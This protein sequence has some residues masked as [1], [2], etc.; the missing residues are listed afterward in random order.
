LRDALLAE[1]ELERLRRLRGMFGSHQLGEVANA[2]VLADLSSSATSTYN[3]N[4][5]TDA[6]DDLFAAWSDGWR[7][8]VAFCLSHKQ[9]EE[10]FCEK[11]ECWYSI[12]E[13]QKPVLNG[14]VTKLREMGCRP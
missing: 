11:V 8:A 9:W 7:G 4:V 6:A 14:M 5:Y 1:K 12:S 3:G 2:A 13:K 10:A